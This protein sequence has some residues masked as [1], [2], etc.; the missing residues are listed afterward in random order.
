MKTYLKDK[1]I[2]R[3]LIKQ[4][5]SAL[6]E[7]INNTVAQYFQSWRFYLPKIYKPI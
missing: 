1:N 5:K 4:N 6:K 2:P 7:I 3:E